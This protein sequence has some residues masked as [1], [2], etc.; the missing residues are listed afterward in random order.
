MINGVESGE[1]HKAQCGNCKYIIGMTNREH[2]SIRAAD[3]LVY[4]Y[5]GMAVITCKLCNAPN[6]VVDDDYEKQNPEIVY[7]AEQM[8]N[9][10]RA[11]FVRWYPS[12]DHNNRS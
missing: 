1:M 6:L 5:G 4:F 12:K 2:L 10:C 7:K 8:L 11:V 9:S 3:L